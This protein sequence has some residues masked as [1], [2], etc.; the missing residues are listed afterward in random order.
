M[1]TKRIEG[2]ADLNKKIEASKAQFP[3]VVDDDQ[4]VEKKEE[5]YL[6]KYTL[7][8]NIHVEKEYKG[9]KFVI[10]IIMKFIYTN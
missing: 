2:R 3:I 4:L 6:F 8:L 1:T 9:E 10:W 5:F 7:F